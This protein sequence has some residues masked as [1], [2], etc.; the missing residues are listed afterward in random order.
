LPFQ[1]FWIETLSFLPN[2]Q[3]DGHDLGRNGPTSHGGPHPGGQQGS[4]EGS[5]RAGSGTGPSGRALEQSFQLMVV[6]SD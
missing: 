3:N 4:I 5:E 6:I 1:L 2:G